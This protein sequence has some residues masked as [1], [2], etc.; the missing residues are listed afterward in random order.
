MRPRGSRH[1][2]GPSGRAPSSEECPS[3]TPPERGGT[4]A[5]VRLDL[6]NQPKSACLPPPHQTFVRCR[7]R[8][9]ATSIAAPRGKMRFEKPTRRILQIETAME[10]IDADELVEVTPDAVRV[11]KQILRINMRP[12]RANAIEDSQ[13]T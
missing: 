6:Q 7:R 12:S 13:S 11:R 10:W 3:V 4:P 9:A 2:G 5:D 1:A 8:G